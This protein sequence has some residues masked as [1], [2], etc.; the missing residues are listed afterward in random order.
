VVELVGEWQFRGW[1]GDEWRWHVNKPWDTPGW[2]PARVPGSVVDDLA[3]AAEVP[4]PYFERQSRLAEWASERTWVYRT[5]VR[6]A[7]ALQFDGVD[8]ACEVF[9]DGEAAASHTGLFTPFAVDVPEGEHLLA[10][11]IHPSPESEAQVGVTSRVRV[12]KPRMNYGWDFCP[13]LVHQGIW[14]RV[15]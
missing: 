3:R 1:L 13:R 5:H 4:S 8:Y 15:G 2:L 6:G 7:G 9:V 12:H 11:A 10:V 14:R